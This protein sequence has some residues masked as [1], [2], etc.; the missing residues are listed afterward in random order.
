LD[1]LK[2]AYAVLTFSGHENLNKDE[3]KQELSRLIQ[4]QQW[5][6]DQV[7]KTRARDFIDP[8]RRITYRNKR[9]M[10]AVVGKAESNSFTQYMANKSEDYCK[11]VEELI[12][13]I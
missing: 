10:E 9:E 2:H 1:K 8:F 13:R 11:A 5:I 3:F 7:Y 6:N 12:T 4:T